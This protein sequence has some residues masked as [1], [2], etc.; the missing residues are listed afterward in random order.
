MLFACLP[1]V[2]RH[3]CTDSHVS[4][5]KLFYFNLF[6]ASKFGLKFSLPSVFFLTLGK[7]GL[8]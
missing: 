7:E 1:Q 4:S 2:K 6:R 8:C 3:T 5:S